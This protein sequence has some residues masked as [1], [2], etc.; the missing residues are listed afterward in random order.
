M[1]SGRFGDVS[2][3]VEK[4]FVGGASGVAA[5]VLTFPMDVLRRRMQV[6]VA[7]GDGVSSREGGE[8]LLHSS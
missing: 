8:L 4:F 2:P 3:F 1:M 6:M 5:S 7:A